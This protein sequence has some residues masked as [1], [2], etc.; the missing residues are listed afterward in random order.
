M[1]H[2]IVL[3]GLNSL[4]GSG[5]L[6]ASGSVIISL[7]LKV[8]VALILF[9]AGRKLIAWLVNLCDK[10][11]ERQGMEVTVR[12]FLKN[13]LIALGYV[14]LVMVLLEVVGIAAT[15]FA[16]AFASCG[17]AIGLA[18]QGSLSNFAGGLLILLMKPFGV[19]DY[20]VAGGD[21]GTVKEIGLVYTK[22]VTGDNRVVTIP[23]GNLANG[24]V[25][26]VTANPTRRVDVTVGIGYS[27]DLKKAK[28][29]LQRL[30]ENDAARLADK[31]VTVFVGELGAS[32]VNL[33]LR[34]WVDAANYWAAKWRLTETIKEEFDKAGIEIPFNQLDVHMK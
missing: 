23:N 19:G 13:V 29:I 27:S 9:V 30:G 11:F 7:I 22:L 15:S 10:I 2:A 8:V 32:S 24:S 5:L 16:A 4:L 25:T 34:I 14:V 6:A 26:N 12:R 3:S 31:D 21:E 1:K 17:V 33:G 20:I 18:L 28:E